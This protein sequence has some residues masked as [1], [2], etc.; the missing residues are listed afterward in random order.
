MLEMEPTHDTPRSLC[1]EI[2]GKSAFDIRLEE[3][4]CFMPLLCIASNFHPS[5]IFIP[6]GS[7]SLIKY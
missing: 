6:F 4:L 5:S 2:K 3:I 1:N 7:N